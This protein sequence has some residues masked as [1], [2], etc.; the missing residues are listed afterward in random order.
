MQK[1]DSFFVHFSSDTDIK[2][3]LNQDKI[4]LSMLNTLLDD[5]SKDHLY[6][7]IDTHLVSK[8]DVPEGILYILSIKI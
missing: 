6:K 5:N 7:I 1:I 2:N 4:E 3:G 8:N